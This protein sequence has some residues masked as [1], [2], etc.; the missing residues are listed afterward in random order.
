MSLFDFACI[1]ERPS[2]NNA[3]RSVSLCK[4]MDLVA[5][6]YHDGLLIVYRTITWEKI[7]SKSAADLEISS[8]SII[9]FNDNGKVI[10]IGSQNGEI[11][12]YCLEGGTVYQAFQRLPI[13]ARVINNMLWILCD[14]RISLSQCNVSHNLNK[15]SRIVNV[16]NNMISALEFEDHTNEQHLIS[17][18][19]AES[20]LNL[21]FGFTESAIL[22]SMTCDGLCCGFMHGI[23]PL[24]SIDIPNLLN[25]TSNK[26]K[27]IPTFST[28]IHTALCLEYEQSTN[29]IIYRTFNLNSLCHT[30]FIRSQLAT[31][32][33]KITRDFN[34]L[35]DIVMIGGKK[36]K[37]AVKPIIPKLSLLQG[38]LDSYQ[39]TMTPVEFMYTISIC[40]LW[41]PASVTAFSQHW[42]EQGL[43][44]LRSAVDTSSRTFIKQLHFRALPIATNIILK[45]SSLLH[46]PLED[47]IHTKIKKVISSSELLLS[48]LDDTLNEAKLARESMLLYLNFV[49]ECSTGA[50]QDANGQV[51]KLDN[52]LREKCRKIFDP[53]KYR[54][55]SKSS[56]AQAECVTATHLYAYTQD[57]ELAKDLVESRR[58]QNTSNIVRSKSVYCS[59]DEIV[60][61]SLLQQIRI[62]KELVQDLTSSQHS[63]LNSLI[64]HKLES[65]TDSSRSSNPLSA[66][67]FDDSLCRDSLVVPTF[68]AKVINS[69]S[70]HHFINCIIHV[71]AGSYYDS[72]SQSVKNEMYVLLYEIGKLDTVFHSQ[73][74]IYGHSDIA[75]IDKVKLSVKF[76]VGTNKYSLSSSMILRRIN[77][78]HH[79]SSLSIDD[80][81]FT[82]MNLNGNTLNFEDLREFIV[83]ASQP[84]GA[85]LRISKP[86]KL[87]SV[88]IFD[89][90]GPRGIVMMT[91]ATGKVIV[92]DLENEDDEEIEDDDT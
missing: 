77:G 28:P 3:I 11:T 13:D 89:A 61:H 15:N 64:S 27:M 39:I 63:L 85:N 48:K 9:A 87:T 37:E 41:H 80:I 8:P 52:A 34:K 17:N 91:E 68:F 71:V 43:C 29:L 70:S 12:L 25:G 50:T 42:N 18:D 55:P 81:I 46:I 20:E 78:Q 38:L 58:G 65:L 60:K 5:L 75:S 66:I 84:A 88:D 92:L 47:Q 6:L 2:I 59:D 26:F 40:G 73:N 53:R 4:S 1:Q 32:L 14:D 36:W 33:S 21:L 56:S 22:I 31:N 30:F 83:K 51:H 7:I 24:F 69:E 54:A 82:P 10:A 49:K 79:L 90:C 72:I 35:H 19:S 23:F 62:T 16:L 44:R 57:S 86:L 45:C 76:D 74:L 67:T